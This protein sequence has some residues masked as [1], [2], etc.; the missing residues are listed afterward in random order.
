MDYK[1]LLRKYIQHISDCEGMTLMDCLNAGGPDQVKFTEAEVAEL[2]AL[3]D[4][5]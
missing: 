4:H 2:Y 1:E 5:G 3:D